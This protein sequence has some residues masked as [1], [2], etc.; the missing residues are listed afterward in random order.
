M[1]SKEKIL[2]VDTDQDSINIL[3]DLLHKNYEIQSVSDLDS[4][5][6]VVSKNRPNL[7]FLD[8][9]QN[10]GFEIANTLKSDS[11]TSEIPIIFTIKLE[12]THHIPMVFESGGVD[13]ISKPFNKVFA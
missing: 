3:I 4:T 12:D 5:L 2:I 11:L 7:I 8:S 6:N 9:L 13:Y 10:D 1:N